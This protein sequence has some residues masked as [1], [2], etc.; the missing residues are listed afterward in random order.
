MRH[1]I[2]AVASAP[3]LLAAASAPAAEPDGAAVYKAKCASCHG[4]DGRGETPI[5]KAR[6]VKSLLDPR[7]AGADAPAA[8]AKAVREGGFRACLPWG[9]S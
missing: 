7:W 8:I 6:K 4:A 2:L 5:G 9:A 3:T 1:S